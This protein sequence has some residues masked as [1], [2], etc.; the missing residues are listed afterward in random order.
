M[1]ATK[2]KVGLDELEKE[3]TIDRVEEGDFGIPS[4]RRYSSIA[5]SLN[6][7]N[8]G[9]FCPETRAYTEQVFNIDENRF[10]SSNY[11]V[12]DNNSNSL[13]GHW[14]MLYESNQ[15][16]WIRESC[17][18]TASVDTPN[19]FHLQCNEIPDTWSTLVYD[20]STDS[21]SISISVR[22]G[23][24]DDEAAD[25]YSRTATT[26]GHVT[27]MNRID[28]STH[29][30]T[31]YLDIA[32][33]RVESTEHRLTLIRLGDIGY[34][35]G[36]LTVEKFDFDKNLLLME[37]YDVAKYLEFDGSL[38]EKNNIALYTSNGEL[39]A[40]FPQ[41]LVLKN[42]TEIADNNLYGNKYV[43]NYFPGVSIDL[44]DSEGL[45]PTLM[46]S[47]LFG[48]FLRIRQFDYITNDASKMELDCLINRTEATR[49]ERGD[50][51]GT[52]RLVF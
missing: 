46:K 50:M 10:N 5:D 38:E 47:S 12:A 24:T 14:M 16:G 13:A 21:V 33:D 34:S 30:V 15:F 29:I 25:R 9:F 37:E 1:G 51:K 27:N 48:S 52:L 43:I 22:Y 45:D 49:F 40:E 35:L 4:C 28:V 32:P 23:T 8:N 31:E 42:T 20:A 3:Q 19:T 17:D 41:N 6:P 44:F 7:L 36:K 11:T 39:L 2:C 26:T 18:L